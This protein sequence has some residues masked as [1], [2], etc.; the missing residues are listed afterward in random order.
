MHTHPEQK[1]CKKEAKILRLL[2]VLRMYADFLRDLRDFAKSNGRD[3]ISLT[4]KGCG[5]PLRLAVALDKGQSVLLCGK[6]FLKN[7]YSIL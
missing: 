3:A 6:F 2:E 5:G 1:Q 4:G 7:F